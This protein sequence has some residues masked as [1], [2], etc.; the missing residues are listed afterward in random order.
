MVLI[1]FRRLK[2]GKFAEWTNL[3]LPK[4]DSAS[5][6]ILEETSFARL[7]S[8][9]YN[10]PVSISTPKELSRVT[11][12]ADYYFALRVL[13]SAL[14]GILLRSAPMIGLLKSNVELVLETAHKLRSPLLFRE[15]LILSVGPWTSPTY[16]LF[17]NK[18]LRKV[19]QTACHGVCAKL[20][21]VHSLVLQQSSHTEKVRDEVGSLA[22]DLDTKLESVFL[23]QY[24]RRVSEIVV[25]GDE[26]LFLRETESLLQ[27]NLMLHHGP[28]SGVGK[29]KDYFLCAEIADEELPWDQNQ[30]D[31]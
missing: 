1:S 26:K 4:L 25:D 23:P 28:R 13:S 22:W 7:L 11:E 6:Q 3:V 18:K 24:Y 8:V 5:K 12:M 21:V 17:K 30:T 29:F 2:I 19:A 16:L 10:K 14:D 31:W 20:A 27:K 15:C 9:M